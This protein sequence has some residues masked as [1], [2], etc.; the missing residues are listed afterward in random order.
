[1]IDLINSGCETSLKDI[2]KSTVIWPQEKAP[3]VD[4]HNSWSTLK[5]QYILQ[6]MHDVL[7]SEHQI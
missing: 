1:M 2:G 5:Q 6:N 7:W 4:I 3:N